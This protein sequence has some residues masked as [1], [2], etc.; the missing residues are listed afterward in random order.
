MLESC[1]IVMLNEK[2]Q[3]IKESYKHKNSGYHIDYLVPQKL[4]GFKNFHIDY[5]VP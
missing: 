3:V 5:L 4:I 1:S 2:A